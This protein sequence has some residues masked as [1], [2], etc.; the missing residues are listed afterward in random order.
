MTGAT[1]LHRNYFIDLED[2]GERWR[3]VAI[4]HSVDRS[5]LLPP[6]FNYSDR[7]EAERYARV[8]IDV[9]F[10]VVVPKAQIAP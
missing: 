8:A 4:T 3:V 2:D 10:Q 7:A 6:A 5:S 1:G 9:R